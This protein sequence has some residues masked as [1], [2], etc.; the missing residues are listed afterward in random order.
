WFFHRSS[1][2]FP[3]PKQFDPERRLNNDSVAS[4]RT[5]HLIP[6]GLGPRTCSGQSLAKAALCIAVAV[7]VRNFTITS[8]ASITKASM[9]MGHGFVSCFVHGLNYVQA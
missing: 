7:L 8:H 1:D 6:F 2:V 9:M 3:S 5:A 4:L